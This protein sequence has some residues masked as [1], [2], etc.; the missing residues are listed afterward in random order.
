MSL[1]PELIRRAI[2]RD[3]AVG[4]RDLL[5]QA[6]EAER[7]ACARALDPLLAGPADGAPCPE[8]WLQ[9]ARRLA[10]QAAAFGLAPGA[11]PAGKHAYLLS[12]IL[13]AAE[14]EILARILDDR[15]PPWLASFVDRRLAARNAGP[16]AWVIARRL[17]AL[18]AIERPAIPEYTTRMLVALRRFALN[19]PTMS[20]VDPLRELLADPGLLEDEVWRLFTT[21]GVTSGLE[22]GSARRP[23]WEDA[24]AALAGQGRLDR[25]R[26]LDACL[27]ALGRD[28]APDW[29]LTLHDRLDPSL[30]EME[31][32]ADRY[33][34]L[35]AVS[36]KAVVTFA[37]KACGRL[38]AAGRL[39]AEDF[40]A[41]SAPALLFPGKAVAAAQL[42]LIGTVVAARPQATDLSLAAAAEAFGH[43]RLDVQEAALDLIARYGLPEG[44]SREVIS[45]RAA[46]LA[47]ALEHRAISLGL[48]A[49]SPVPSASPTIPADVSVRAG[50]GPGDPLPPP[51]ADPGELIQLLTQVME[52][53]PDP[54]AVER[55]IAGAVRLCGLPVA[56]RARLAAPLLR[57]AKERLH[58]DYDGPFGGREIRSD[59]AGLTLAWGRG[60]TPDSEDARRVW[61]WQDRQAVLRS[62]QARTMAGILTAR[63]WEASALVAAGQP[64]ELLAE[65]EFGRGAISPDRLIGRLGS[66]AG[67]ALS[68]HD[69]EIALLRLAPGTGDSFWSAW[70]RLH[71]SSRQAA[72]HSYQQGLAPLAFEPVIWRP[73]PYSG[74]PGPAPL[75]RVTAPPA[76][77]AGSRCW[78]LLTA[79]SDPGRDFYR[80]HAH[81]H[82]MGR[83]YRP[84]VAGWSALCPWQ[85][86]LAAAHLLRPLSDSLKPGSGR[87]G[88]AVAALGGLSLSGH[89][90]GEIGH[91][92]VAAGLASAEPYVRIAAAEVW[93]KACRDGRLDP[94]LAARAIVTG[95]T[96][97]AFKLNR[98]ADGLQHAS[99]DP[100][101]AQRI[102]AMVFAAADDLIPAK[103]SDLHLLLGL[104]ARAG[105]PATVPAAITRL[106]AGPNRSQLATAAR[107]LAGAAP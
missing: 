36:A 69:L 91:L 68:R 99:H 105:T 30:D 96:G 100:V 17:V 12:R 9:L 101:A 107:R 78:A 62:G 26:L 88:T 92:A 48:P 67:R 70:A 49:L 53:A 66:W 74:L 42:R 4:V 94:Q 75:A 3:D 79:L 5:R 81:R 54:L 25:G 23:G 104:A 19:G 22:P 98:V 35:L 6:A 95:V 24:L 38:L 40:L 87:A 29:Y 39:P 85:P 41:A 71:S 34:G 72:Q 16:D 90:L 28:L 8:V 84:V 1:D 43:Q 32:R 93:V 77:P 89:A 55:A 52:D 58:D 47:P 65:P 2:E 21:P 51:L 11:I 10:F 76:G 83:G 63:I 82:F 61:G 13:S 33:A 102:V 97:E 64:A 20:H 80:D 73:G 86:E 103:P 60:W 46:L 50:P 14:L 44:P 57:R 56:E 7:R 18:G 37:Q 45:E 106:A 15:R 31:V 27:D 59:I